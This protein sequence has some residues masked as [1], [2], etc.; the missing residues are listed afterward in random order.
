VRQQAFNRLLSSLEDAGAAIVEVE[1]VGQII[2]EADI[3]P[4]FFCECKSCMNAYLATLRPHLAPT[5]LQEIIDYNQRHASRALKYGQPILLHVQNKT[6]GSL[7]EPE[8]LTSLAKRERAI[9]TLDEV[10][11]T[12]HLDTLLCTQPE[13]VAPI[14]GFASMSIPIGSHENR[15][16]IGSYWIAKRYDEATLFRITFAA[17]SLL[18]VKCVPEML[19]RLQAELAS[20]GEQSH[21]ETE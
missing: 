13:I 7:T 8:Y 4:V 10:F 14:T 20:R 2:S 15:I 19:E 17:E 9:H 1:D 6:S 16:P 12:H 11:D 5:S 21:M 3:D 18:E